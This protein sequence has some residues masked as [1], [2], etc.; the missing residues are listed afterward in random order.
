MQ[1]LVPL[2]SHVT[3]EARHLPPPPASSCAPATSRAAAAERAAPEV[4]NGARSCPHMADPCPALVSLLGHTGVDSTEARAWIA[5][6]RPCESCRVSF[7]A[8]RASLKGLRLGSRE[9]EILA[10]AAAEEVFVVTAPGMSRSL[11]AARR[12]AAQTLTRAGLVGAPPKG[13]GPGGAPVQA[14]AAVVLTTM[15]RYVLAAFGRFIEG[16]KPVRWTRPRAGVALPGREPSA[17]VAEALELARAELHATLVD[18]K[19]VLFAAVARPVR[20]PGL[21]DSVTRQLQVKAKGLRD[22]LEPAG[23]NGLASSG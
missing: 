17:L 3:G 10:G 1:R 14:R 22:L 13:D 23:P 8:R 15:G 7:E 5:R 11:S 12:R 19:R 6:V 21:L 4:A 2:P 16:D 9:R 18:L 20:D